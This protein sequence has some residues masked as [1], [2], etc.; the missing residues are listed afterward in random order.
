MRYRS[1]NRDGPTAGTE[2]VDPLAFL[3]RVT[4]HIPATH[5]VVTRYDGDHANRV[6]GA[7]KLH[8]VIGAL[9]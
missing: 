5:Q 4:A 7:R 2:M 8:A 3:A 9:S 6:R 1:D